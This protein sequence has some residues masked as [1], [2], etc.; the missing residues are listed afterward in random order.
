MRRIA[1]SGVPKKMNKYVMKK[2]SLKLAVGT[3]DGYTFGNS[4]TVYVDRG[5][6]GLN[7][8]QELLPLGK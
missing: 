4:A 2:V 1:S 5:S 7:D 3:V 6:C 8:L